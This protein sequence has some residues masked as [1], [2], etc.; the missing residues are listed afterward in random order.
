MPA[1]DPTPQPLLTPAEVAG[2]MLFSSIMTFSI[3]SAQRV[4]QADQVDVPV[5]VGTVAGCNMAWGLV[6]AGMRLF[7]ARVGKVEQHRRRQAWLQ[8]PDLGALRG[9]LRADPDSADLAEM[10]DA[11][12]LAFLQRQQAAPYAQGPR[13]DWRDG[14]SAALVWLCVLL[15]TV[16]LLLPFLVHADAARAM[17][18]AQVVAVGLMFLL[19][20]RVSRG[21]GTRPAWG[22]LLFAGFGVVITVLCIALGG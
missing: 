4:A 19:G 17:R 6:D 22:G 14:A 8:A 11:A 21:L 3:L 10:D 1:P 12:L 16:P 9:L 13:L 2:E 7:Q 15:P 18:S 20:A 5:L